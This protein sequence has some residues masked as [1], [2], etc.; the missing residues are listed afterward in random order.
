[1]AVFAPLS[2]KGP[3]FGDFVILPRRA[4]AYPDRMKVIARGLIGLLTVVPAMAQTATNAADRALQP[5]R[6]RFAD[7]DGAAAPTVPV[8]LYD[9]HAPAVVRPA[10]SAALAPATRLDL[11]R[12][13]LAGQGQSRPAIAMEI[14]Q[15]AQ[16]IQNDAD[17]R[18]AFDLATDPDSLPEVSIEREWGWLAGDVKRLEAETAARAMLESTL[19]PLR[20]DRDDPFELD[21]YEDP[22]SLDRLDRLDRRDDA[23]PD[24]GRYSFPRTHDAPAPP[25]A[26]GF[27]D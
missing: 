5:L 14:V 15:Q 26:F 23:A 25:D 10:S 11:S 4:I 13:I 3:D 17:E 22:L 6:M 9:A 7:D 2:P 8:T 18:S 12:L 27:G 20:M 19:T 1:M 16:W 21:V 24:A